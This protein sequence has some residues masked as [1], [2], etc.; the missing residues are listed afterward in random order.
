ML[1]HVN[2]SIKIATT[3]FA[4]LAGLVLHYKLV[5]AVGNF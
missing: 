1:A 4:R 2:N 5:E 3:F